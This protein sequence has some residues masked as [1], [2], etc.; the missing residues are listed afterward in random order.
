MLPVELGV[1]NVISFIKSSHLARNSLYQGIKT[2]PSPRRHRSLELLVQL[3]GLGQAL[4]LGAL[5]GDLAVVVRLGRPGSGDMGG[6]LGLDGL[7][8]AG[9][10]LLAF[11]DGLVEEIHLA[12]VLP[13]AEAQV[14]E[15]LR[16]LPEW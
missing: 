8:E 5:L 7:D 16:D 2:P 3:L 1:S 9:A 6:N 4:L 14:G 10:F 11:V 12:T 15:P 13:V